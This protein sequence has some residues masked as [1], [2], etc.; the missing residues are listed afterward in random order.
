MPEAVHPEE[1]ALLLAAVAPHDHRVG[2]AVAEPERQAEPVELGI[3]ERARAGHDVQADLPGL[4]R[5]RLRSR[6]GFVAPV[7]SN[8]PSWGSCQTQ[9]R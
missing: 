3:D 4:S 7:K 5:K 6:P 8:E 9:G 2:V 1:L